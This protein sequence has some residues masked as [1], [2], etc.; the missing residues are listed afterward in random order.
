MKKS[1][2]PQDK[3]ALINFTRE[4]CYV[5][6]EDGKYETELSTGWDAK[7]VALDKAWEEIDT[8][9]K[10]AEEQVRNGQ[11]SP[12]LYFMELR[13]MDFLVLSG[14]T[15]FWQWQIKRHL[16]PKI[17]R[18]LSEQKLNKYAAA[19]DVTIEELKNYKPS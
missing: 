2:L 5:K 3:S 4:L 1:E 9:I 12:I 15:G 19:F 11:A 13:L 16:T 14:Y 7:T 8:R 6:N 10:Y 18:R 17:F